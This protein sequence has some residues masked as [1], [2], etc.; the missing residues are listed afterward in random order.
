MR[1]AETVLAVIKDR[2]TATTTSMPEGW[3]AAREGY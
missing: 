1:N 3:M 2:G